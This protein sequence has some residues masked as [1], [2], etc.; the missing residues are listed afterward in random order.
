MS[1]ST[2]ARLFWRAPRISLA[3]DVMDRRV[4]LRSVVGFVVSAALRNPGVAEPFPSKGKTA[5]VIAGVWPPEAGAGLDVWAPGESSAF[6]DWTSSCPVSGGD[7][8]QP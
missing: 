5:H 8:G 3:P 1:T 7:L 6:S 2:P 4:S